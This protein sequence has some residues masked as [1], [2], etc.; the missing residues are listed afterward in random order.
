MSY[1]VLVELAPVGLS[2]LSSIVAVLAAR[3]V[4]NKN[5]RTVGHERFYAGESIVKRSSALSIQDDGV[6]RDA[7]LLK[8]YKSDPYV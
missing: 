5:L 4:A 8:A 6:I 1:S 7:S 3:F 2:A